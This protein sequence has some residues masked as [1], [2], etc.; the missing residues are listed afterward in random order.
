MVRKM[1]L[2][3]TN[4]DDASADFPAFVLHITD[5]SPNRKTPLERDIRVSSSLEQVE[6]LWETLAAEYFV[7]GWAIQG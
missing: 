7:K 3:K 4:K 1:V 5:F 6:A 2:W